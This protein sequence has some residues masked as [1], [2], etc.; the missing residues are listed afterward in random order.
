[1]GA[2]SV[3]N[4]ESFAQTLGLNTTTFN[5]CLTSNKYAQAVAAS[6]AE[7]TNA[8]VTGT[9]TGFILVNGKVVDTIGG[10]LPLA[11][12]TAKLDA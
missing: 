6:K 11:Q 12:V 1:M 2:F 7:G 4:L 8:G 10:Y 5:Q 3:P 9:P